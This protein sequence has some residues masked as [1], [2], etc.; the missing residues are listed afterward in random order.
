MRK[1]AVGNVAELVH[2][3]QTVKGVGGNA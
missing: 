1:L 2:L 3:V